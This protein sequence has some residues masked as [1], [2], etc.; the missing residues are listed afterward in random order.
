MRPA[1]P[2]FE[3]DLLFSDGLGLESAGPDARLERQLRREARALATLLLDRGE[4]LVLAESCTAG[5]VSAALGE[6]P[7]ISAVLAGSW[8]TYQVESKKRW[9]SVSPSAL[10]ARPDAVSAEVAESMALQALKKTPRAVWAAS[11]TGHLNSPARAWAAVAQ[12]G[13]QLPRRR[14]TARRISLTHTSLKIE[15]AL[16]EIGPSLD[17][18]N[19]RANRQVAASILL[20]R[21]VRALITLGVSKTEIS[22]TS[23]SRA[24]RQ[25]QPRGN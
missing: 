4:T 5:R 9:L 12:R 21:M 6:V 1:S 11:I 13:A 16:S 7:G 24:R 8:V 17:R 23:L 14:T 25:T 3:T 10:R 19:E 18:K 2:G 20:L 22:G 15:K